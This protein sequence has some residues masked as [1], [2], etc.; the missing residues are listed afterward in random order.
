MTDGV[1]ERQRAGVIILARIFGIL[2]LVGA[3]RAETGF[4]PTG[5]RVGNGAMRVGAGA[6]AALRFRGYGGRKVCP[7][8]GRRGNAES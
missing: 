2:G 3:E 1:R 7:D 6:N 4:A 5:C 8:F